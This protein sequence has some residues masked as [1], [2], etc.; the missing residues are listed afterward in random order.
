[1]IEGW[2]GEALYSGKP[3]MSLQVVLLMGGCFGIRYG[4]R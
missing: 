4:L 3:Y 2:E 1:M